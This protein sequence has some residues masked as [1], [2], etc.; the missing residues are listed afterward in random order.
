[1]LIEPYDISLSCLEVISHYPLV[2]N[3]MCCSSY[4]P[5]VYFWGLWIQLTGRMLSYV[6]WKLFHNLCCCS[7]HLLITK[8]ARPWTDPQNCTHN[9]QDIYFLSIRVLWYPTAEPINI[10]SLRRS[11]EWEVP[12]P[13]ILAVFLVFKA[14]AHTTLLVLSWNLNHLPA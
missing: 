11:P 12:I 2:C 10:N 1:M 9:N 13:F 8:Y 4:M 7:H 3:S 14:I 6:L 5:Q